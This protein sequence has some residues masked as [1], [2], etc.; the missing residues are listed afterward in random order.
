MKKIIII[1]SM[2]LMLAAGLT[3]AQ[4]KG[5]AT[6][7][8]SKTTAP[9]VIYTGEIAKTV[10]GY[11]GTTPLNIYVIEGKIV[12]IEAL[13]NREDP[14]YFKRAAAKVFA[15]YEGKTIAE[16]KALKPDVATGAT[17]SSEALIK[18]I[19]MGL[20]QVKEP[21]KTAPKKKMPKKR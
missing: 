10:I 19:Q 7:N 14:Q 17:Y 15:Q 3:T 8:A 9:Q 4:A 2:A 11:N 13:Q 12:K 21:R 6:K 20:N 5:K 18:N 1:F 16:A